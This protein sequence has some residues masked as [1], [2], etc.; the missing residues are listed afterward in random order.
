MGFFIRQY[1]FKQWFGVEQATSHYLN[2]VVS[3]YSMPMIYHIW[4]K[5]L[6]HHYFRLWLG[7]WRHHTITWTN[8]DLWSV[9]PARIHLDEIQIN[10]WNII[11]L[12]YNRKCSFPKCQ[13]LSTVRVTCGS[14]F[15]WMMSW[16]LHSNP[17]PP[18]HYRF[19]S[20]TDQSL[21]LS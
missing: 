1:S 3:S 5:I 10:I 21:F 17:T 15:G 20:S 12:K 16:L 11:I 18:I 9:R 2:Q 7:A 13:I 6:E 4:V 14:P 19:N 8:A